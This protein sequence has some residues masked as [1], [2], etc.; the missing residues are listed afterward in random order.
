M[1]VQRKQLGEWVICVM[2][3][4]VAFCSRVFAYQLSL[5]WQL[6]DALMSHFWKCDQG[7]GGVSCAEC[8][9]RCSGMLALVSWR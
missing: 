9:H 1:V 2:T 4:C 3:E 6:G 8:I 5:A 7:M